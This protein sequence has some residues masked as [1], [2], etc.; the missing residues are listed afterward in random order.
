[1]PI[2]ELDVVI[3]LVVITAISGFIGLE[4]EYH[5]KPAGLRTN[6]MVGLGSTVMTIAGLRAVDLFVNAP[7]DPTRIAG[8]VITGIGFIG[9]GAILRPSGRGVSNVVGLTTAATLWVVSGLGIAVGMGL[10]LEALLA[11]LLVFFTFFVLGRMV[12]Y[13]RR[14]SKN[15]PTDIK[16]HEEADEKTNHD[17]EDPSGRES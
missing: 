1:M 3:R 6:I 11:T 17:N 4:R 8:Q 5:A 16:A 2:T 7:V 12:T 13:I 15:Y 14:H 9:A 10:Y